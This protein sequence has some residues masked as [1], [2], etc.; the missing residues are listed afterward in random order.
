MFHVLSLSFSSLDMLQASSTL[1]VAYSKFTYRQH[2][3]ENYMKFKLCACIIIHLP[4]FRCIII[5]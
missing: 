2:I 4:N 5:I 3:Q 1:S